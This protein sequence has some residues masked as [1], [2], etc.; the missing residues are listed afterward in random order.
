[1]IRVYNTLAREKEDFTT[2]EPGK[3]GMY[4]CGPTVYKPAHIGHMVGPVIFDT[5]KRFLEYSGYD[6][7]FVINITDVDDKLINKAAEL[8]TSM[9][10]LAEEMTADYLD[11]LSLMGIDSIDHFPKATDYIGEM[12]EIISKLIEDDHAYPMDGD[13]YFH[14]TSDDDYGKLSGRKVEDTLAGTRVEANTQKRHP[15]DFALW[16][17]S[18]PDDPSWDSP[19][20]PG[21]PGWHIECSAMSMKLL[22]ETIDIHGGG[23]DLMFPHHENEL[24]QSESYTGKPFSC[25]WMHNGL[26]QAS[27]GSKVG[28]AH[29]SEGDIDEQV[30]GKLAG[31]AGAESVKTAVFAHYPPETVRFF[32]LGTH[33]RSP[34]DYSLER[35]GEVG[36][37]L[38]QFHRLFETYERLTGNSFYT[39]DAT[40][41]RDASS[42]LDGE[43]AE[44]FSELRDLRDRFLESMDDDFNTGGA[45]GVLFEIRKAIGGFLHA[46]DATESNISD[47]NATALTAAMTLLKELANTLGVFRAPVAAAAGGADDE[48][49]GHLFDLIIEVRGLA[50]EAKNWA[51]ADTIRDRLTELEVTLEDRPEGTTWK[52]G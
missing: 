40:T 26:M 45:I 20:G 30:A 3:V 24:A 41:R 7:T 8:G 27:S 17:K 23:L 31:S 34:I 35:I 18:N 36:K 10:S 32:L 39:I 5:V 42:A 52:R 16:K 43:P 2:V 9:E 29:S 33:Y 19:W 6:V 21:R 15:A 38:E 47:E 12:Q 44:F 13:V 37:G 4:L 51:I 28:G 49:V 50:R 22:G 46:A 48:F 11:N 25:Y 14:V 1:M